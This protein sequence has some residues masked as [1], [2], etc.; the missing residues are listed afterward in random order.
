MR[1]VKS[2]PYNA[3][4]REAQAQA[5]RTRVLA[6]AR[7]L[8]RGQGYGATTIAAIAHAA[9]V[10]VQTIYATFGSKRTILEAIALGV[11]DS[12]DVPQLEAEVGATNDARRQLAAI[13]A[14]MWRLWSLG[15]DVPEM[16]RGAAAV[17]PSLAGIYQRGEDR[18][19]TEQ[20]GLV[21]GWARARVLRPGMIP[22]EASDIL[23]T[24]TSPDLFRLL[25][26]QSHW[27]G[28]RYRQWLHETLSNALLGDPE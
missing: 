15:A 6:A 5:T 27:S 11:T 9:G 17:D 22:A 23:W 19:R 24:L 12:A 10:S 26:T 8:F 3:P 21:E 28:E 16:V 4:R 20:A 18:R 2:R 1:P 7:E 25:V 14:F 13:V